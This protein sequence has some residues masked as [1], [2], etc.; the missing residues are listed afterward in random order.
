MG[1]SKAFSLGFDVS[2]S[3]ALL[4]L[5]NLY[6]ETFEVRNS[7]HTFRRKMGTKFESD[8]RLRM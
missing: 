8:H 2:D 6:I 5:D 3:I 4:R 1:I 7:K